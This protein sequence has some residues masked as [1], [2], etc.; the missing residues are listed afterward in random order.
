VT[1]EGSGDSPEHQPV[2]EGDD[3]SGEAMLVWNGMVA[4]I[5]R[6]PCS[7]APA[8]TPTRAAE[9]AQQVRA[10]APAASG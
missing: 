8:Q 3:D 7:D 9:A 6:L 2:R 5:H 10:R 1:G 4:R